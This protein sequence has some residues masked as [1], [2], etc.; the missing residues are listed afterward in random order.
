MIRKMTLVALSAACMAMVAAPASAQMM[1]E[2]ATTEDVTF[3]ATVVD[4]S[5]RLVYGMTGEMHRE[6]SQ[7]CAD[8]GI[9]LALLSSDGTYY[10]PV[11]AAMPGESATAM[12]RPH[13]EHQVTV[14][15]KRINRAGVNSIIIESITM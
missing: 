5:C 12:L 15:G 6:C 3:T 9:P 2:M 4:T 14:R 8:R 11:S 10:I 1:P 13:A 7:V